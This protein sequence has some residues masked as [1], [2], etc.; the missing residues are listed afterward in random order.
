MKDIDKDKLELL[1]YRYN[2][3]VKI[4]YKVAEDTN[5]ASLL[6][7]DDVITKLNEQEELIKLLRKELHKYRPSIFD[8]VKQNHSDIYYLYKGELPDMRY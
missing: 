1:R 4:D 6:S 8:N 2:A 7:L 3:L 5:T